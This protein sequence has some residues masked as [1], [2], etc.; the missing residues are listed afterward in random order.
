[1]LNGDHLL[2][3]HAI[4]FHQFLIK[5]A[6]VPRKAVGELQRLLSIEDEQLTL[7]IGRELLNVLTIHDQSATLIV[8]LQC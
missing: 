6:I 4:D 7:L 5:Q 8:H 3:L 1:V 2:L